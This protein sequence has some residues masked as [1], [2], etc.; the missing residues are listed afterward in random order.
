MSI[1]FSRYFPYIFNMSGS[2]E[3]VKKFGSWFSYEGAPRAQIF[4]R[5]QHKVV[6][7]NSMMK[8]MRLVSFLF[9]NR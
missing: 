2:L 1:T 5:D 4:K 3:S 6:D 7:M 8:L 9:H